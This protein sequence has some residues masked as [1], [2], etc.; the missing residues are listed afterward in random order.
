MVESSGSDRALEL[1]LMMMVFCEEQK[2]RQQLYASL[3]WGQIPGGLPFERLAD[4]ETDG[5]CAQN[6]PE[7]S[8]QRRK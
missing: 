4:N 2:S 3:A 5:R 1:A 7:V 6:S 8:H